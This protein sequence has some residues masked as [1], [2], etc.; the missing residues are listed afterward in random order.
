MS[1]T[2]KCPQC[3]GSGVV[4]EKWFW[5]LNPM[6]SNTESRAEFG[7][8][9][10]SEEAIAFLSAERVEPYSDT[11]PD[12]FNPGGDKTY[13]KC[14]RKDG[15][16]EWFNAPDGVKGA[17]DTFRHG[18]WRTIADRV[19]DFDASGLSIELEGSQ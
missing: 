12:V 15:P 3:N 9:H 4:E 1:D 19:E 6:Q 5:L 7:P 13:R 18:L 16:L 14:F 8:Y 11:G 2:H 17:E 10:S